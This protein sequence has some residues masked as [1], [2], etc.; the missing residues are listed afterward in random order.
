LNWTGDAVFL[1]QPIEIFDIQIYMWLL[2]CIE[3]NSNI[4]VLVIEKRFV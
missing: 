2:D 1:S 4:A 3:L